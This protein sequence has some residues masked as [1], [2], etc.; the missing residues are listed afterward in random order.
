[1]KEPTLLYLEKREREREKERE[2]E[3]EK[4]KENE[5]EKE[6]SDHRKRQIIVEKDGVA[7]T[8]NEAFCYCLLL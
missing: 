6:S 4:D 8:E 3:R 2:N 7:T 5:R 1:M